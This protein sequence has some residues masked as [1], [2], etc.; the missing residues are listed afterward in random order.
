M[1]EQGQDDRTR[2]KSAAQRTQLR[3]QVRRLRQ[4]LHRDIDELS[5]L[6]S[7]AKHREE[8]DQVL[9]DLDRQIERAG[10]AAVITLVGATG[11]G[12][13]TLLN[14]LAGSPIAIEGVDR[15]TTRHP[16][17]FAPRDADVSEL[18]GPQIEQ[19]D[20]SDS[21][22]KVRVVRYEATSGPWTA[23]ILVDAPDMNSVDEQHRAT[24]HALAERSD[25]LVVVLHRQSILEESAVSFLDAFAGRRHLIFV[26]NRI[27]EVT[28]EARA[29]LIKQVRDLALMRWNAPDAPVVAISAR[30]AQNQPNAAGWNEL[31]TELKTLVR[32]S[33]LAGVRRL[34]AIGTASEV[35][36]LFEN[37]RADT[38]ADLEALPEEATNGLGALV[39]RCADEVSTRLALRRADLCELLWIE[40]AKRWDGPGGWALRTGG[41]GSLGLGSAA[42]LATRNPLL[43]AGAAAGAIAADQVQ[44]AVRDRRVTDVS[45]LMPGTTEFESWYKEGLAKA[46]VRAARLAGSPETLGLPSL[47]TIRT[48]VTIAVED[49]WDTLLERDLPAAAE[50]S[51]LRF[52]RL[53]LDLPV[54]ALSAW[55]LYNVGHGFVAGEYAGMDFLVNA[56][57]I[58]VA[59]LFAVRLLVRRGLSVRAGRLL[60]EVT[61]RTRNALGKRVELV[62]ENLQRL[63]NEKIGALGRIAKLEERWRSVLTE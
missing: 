20:G 40:A 4:E 34:N 19:P 61:A 16:V 36:T 47:A 57:L 22:G 23:Q 15:P 33:T 50:R 54:Y 8:V 18:V 43:A 11:A 9:V 3:S 59:Y 7:F 25:V 31:C 53:L 12:K 62:A 56:L 51:V 49:S 6:S 45:G 29:G 32:E 35:Q 52:F 27:D 10:R 28:E 17:I 60:K 24:V 21:E 5:P 39:E 46:R 55:V 13:S 1:T 63:R 26:L 30:A 41:I 37:I 42:A 58:L 44:Q 2:G 48:D 14:A 38:Q